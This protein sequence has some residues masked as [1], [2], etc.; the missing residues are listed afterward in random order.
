MSRKRGREEGEEAG[1]DTGG[2]FDTGWMVEGCSG[3]S[4]V[5]PRR[6]ST[7]YAPLPGLSRWRWA[8]AGVRGGRFPQGCRW[9]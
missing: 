1:W 3:T 4:G 8:G 6:L 9:Q 5:E 2:R 7:C